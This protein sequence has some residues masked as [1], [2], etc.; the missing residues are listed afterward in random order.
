M[1][2]M[3][4]LKKICSGALLGLSLFAAGL[5]PAQ[6]AEPATIEW[7]MIDLPPIQILNGALRG[8]GYTDK[9]RWRL[10]AGLPE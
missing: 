3:A 5:A 2:R 8:K 7:Y 9:I 10:I 4:S 1:T 6:A